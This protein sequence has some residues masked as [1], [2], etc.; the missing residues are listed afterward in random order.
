MPTGGSSR[1][2]SA[3]PG[4]QIEIGD[5]LMGLRLLRDHRRDVREA[6]AV[7]DARRVQDDADAGAAGH[8]P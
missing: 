4:E 1:R 6:P 8:H 2:G 5:G 7:I 3:E